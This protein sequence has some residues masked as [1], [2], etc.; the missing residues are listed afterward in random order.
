[1]NE[2][3][4]DMT[5]EA[6]VETPKKRRGRPPM[7]PEQKAAAREKREAARKIQESERRVIAKA[8]ATVPPIDDAE[9]EKNF[10][11]A[12]KNVMGADGDKKPKAGFQKM[13]PGQRKKITQ[14]T[15]GTS[16]ADIGVRDAKRFYETHE[17]PPELIGYMAK[18][19]IQVQ[20]DRIRVNGQ[21]TAMLNAIL[22]EE[23][24]KQG[25]DDVKK[26]IYSEQQMYQDHPEMLAITA[27]VTD[28]ERV[29]DNAGKLLDAVTSRSCLA[30]YL[31]QIQGIGPVVAGL[32][33]ANIDIKKFKY[34]SNL[35]S[36]AGLS[37]VNK[38]YSASEAKTYLD[39]AFKESGTRILTET[40]VSQIQDAI[41]VLIEGGKYTFEG[42]TVSRYT[43]D[44]LEQIPALQENLNVLTASST[45]NGP[46][47]YAFR[48]IVELV[49]SSVVV[50]DLEAAIRSRIIAVGGV[51]PLEVTLENIEIPE[52]V[53]KTLQ[54]AEATLLDA[55]V[56]KDDL[57]DEF[58]RKLAVITHRSYNTVLNYCTVVDD[59]TG[60]E[61]RSYSELQVRLTKRPF[62]AALKRALFLFQDQVIKR[63]NNPASLYGQLYNE[64][65]ER[66][67]EKNESGENA[68]AA[69]WALM[70]KK[71]KKSTKSWQAMSEGKLTDGHMMNRALRKVKVVLL[72]HIFEA[73][74]YFE[75]PEGQ[76]PLSY[77]FDEL[78]HTDYRAPEV[79]YKKFY[80]DFYKDI[81]KGQ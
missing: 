17:C 42:I 28:A 81:P 58:L 71:I 74:W 12:L 41:N 34:P 7:T 48:K 45:A 73:A 67:H 44:I 38:W 24:I 22:E 4:K 20:T 64:F 61:I 79:D 25:V 6:A 54:E 9:A 18:R 57:S 60:E 5:N 65:L 51:V 36:Y 47:V 23:R 39:Q 29:E 43:D 35:V 3:R 56:D 53:I 27:A 15:F 59:N 69:H 8:T 11:E 31:R 62:N 14:E 70:T 80:A 72:N 66:E 50:P 32:I 33:S 13:T 77:V 75:D 68:T 21:R 1:M 52:E 30:Q 63:H 19:Y 37:N 46:F 55:K 49:S 26:I 10:E 40:A 16:F 76:H 2:N 78:H